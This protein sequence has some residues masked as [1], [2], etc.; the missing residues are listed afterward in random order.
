MPIEFLHGWDMSLFLGGPPA[1]INLS[2]VNLCW[3]SFLYISMSK[4]HRI[5]KLNYESILVSSCNFMLG[6]INLGLKLLANSISLIMKSD[7]Y[8]IHFIPPILWFIFY[9]SIGMSLKVILISTVWTQCVNVQ[10]SGLAS[11]LNA[12]LPGNLISLIRC[13]KN[14][15]LACLK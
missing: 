15:D 6:F 7:Y 10:E 2:K 14:I 8:V 1:Q 5:L 12:L 11:A 13:D 4:I 3:A 9:G